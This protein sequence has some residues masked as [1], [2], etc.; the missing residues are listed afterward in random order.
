MAGYFR[1]HAGQFRNIPIVRTGNIAAFPDEPL[2]IR[3]VPMN[4]Y[5]VEVRSI[6]GLSGS[7]VFT[8][9]PAFRLVDGQA[10]VVQGGQRHYLLGL[11]KGHYDD[12][13]E[14]L[15]ESAGKI[16]GVNIGIG[17]VTP[18]EDIIETMKNPDLVEHRKEMYESH[19]GRHTNF[20]E[21]SVSGIADAVETLRDETLGRMLNTPPKP[22]NS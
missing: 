4:A 22:R 1:Y 13:D 9:L 7:P 20:K 5:L 18:V 8:N 19:E 3:S 21:D 14:D 6:G 11:L 17:V 15:V 16:E 12:D 2:Q 10:K